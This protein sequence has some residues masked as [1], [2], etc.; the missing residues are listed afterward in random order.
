MVVHV[1]VCGV[2]T[3]G[4]AIACVDA[5]AAAIGINLVPTSPRCVTVERAREIARAIE[6]RA[7]SVGVVADRSVDDMLALK[8]EAGLRCLQLHG[9]E[10]PE[11]LLPLLPHAYKAIR[12]AT[13]DDVARAAAFGGEHVLADAKVEGVLGGSGRR[14]D[15]RLV[16][17]LAR[18]RKLTLAGGLTPDNVAD[19]VRLV[20]PFCVDVASGV[21]EEPGVKDLAKVR[22]FVA[23][24]R[25]A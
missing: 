3:V 5:G 25:S 18:A 11:A 22:A 17:P 16:E 8:K 19:A 1:K 2:T 24:A 9:D 12:V 23:A 20:R 6:G 13:A 7:L 10:P 14:F 15:W 21:E 4:D